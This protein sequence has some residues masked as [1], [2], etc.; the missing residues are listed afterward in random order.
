MSTRL[1]VS[2]ALSNGAELILEGEQARY[3]GRVLRSRVGDP[4]QVFNSD[5]GE[6]SAIIE[7]ISKNAV[8]LRVEERNETATESPLKIHLV[9]GISRGERMDFVVQ[10]ATELG[11]K[12]LTPVLTNHGV[13]KF[14]QQRADKRRQHWQQIANSASEQCGRTRPPLVDAPIALNSWFG[15]KDSADST[16]LVLKPGATVQLA[17]IAPPATKLCLLIG[18]EGG[19]SEREYEDANIAGFQAVALGPRILRT[20]T[21]ALAA[22]TI[23]QSCWGDL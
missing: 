19:F 17:S 16:E 3:L 10:K 11:I 8:T 5:D 22:I 7:N 12:R 15:A 13:V 9:Q 18:P 2:G 14:D 6:W 20:E 4:V 23:A 1:L 21:A